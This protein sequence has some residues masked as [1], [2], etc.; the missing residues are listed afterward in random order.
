MMGMTTSSSISVKPTGAP[1][2]FRFTERGRRL[3]VL[4]CIQGY[5]TYRTQNERAVSATPR[6]GRRKD[7]NSANAA[8]PAAGWFGGTPYL[9]E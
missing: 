9:I 8:M 3:F 1:R 7:N 2:L 6:Q 5:A 4:M